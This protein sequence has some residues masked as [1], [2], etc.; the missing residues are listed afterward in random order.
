MLQLQWVSLK[1]QI[2]ETI[3]SF[4]RF[5]PLL[6]KNAMNGLRRQTRVRM[7]VWLFW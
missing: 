6:H 4:T 2:K 5:D 7:Q 1:K 3:L